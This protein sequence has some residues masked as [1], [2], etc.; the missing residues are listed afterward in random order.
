MPKNMH[1]HNFNKTQ[2][3]KLTKSVN[4][5]QHIQQRRLPT[6]IFVSSNWIFTHKKC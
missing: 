1:N 3:W 4:D 6:H 5:T 2:C